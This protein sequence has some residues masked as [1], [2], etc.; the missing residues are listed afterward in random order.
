MN[1]NRM[2]KKPALVSDSGVRALSRIPLSSSVFQESWLQGVL[3]KEPGILP[4][5]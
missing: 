2:S 4:T 1:E 3:E 5:G